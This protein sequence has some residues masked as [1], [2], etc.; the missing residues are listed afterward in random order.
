MPWSNLRQSLGRCVGSRGYR[1]RAEGQGHGA[2]G[3]Q[4]LIPCSLLS[5]NLRL[6]WA[7]GWLDLGV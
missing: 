3:S 2:E 6:H 7:S 4:C 1:R 5:P